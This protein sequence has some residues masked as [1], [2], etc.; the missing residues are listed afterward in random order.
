M[1][2]GGRRSWKVSVVIFEKY[3]CF[4]LANRIFFAFVHL[5]RV[6]STEIL[7]DRRMRLE[8]FEMDEVKTVSAFDSFA[9]K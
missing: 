8:L 9:I 5:S 6:V 1:S 2:E 4:V 7:S 3:C